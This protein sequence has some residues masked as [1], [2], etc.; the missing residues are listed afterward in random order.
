VPSHALWYVY[1]VRMLST[2]P[3]CSKEFLF[4]RCRS[5]DAANRCLSYWDSYKHCIAGQQV[6]SVRR[7]QD[8]SAVHVVCFHGMVTCHIE[9]LWG[10]CQGKSTPRSIGQ[11]AL[12]LGWCGWVC[13]CVLWFGPSSMHQT[14]QIF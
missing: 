1:A 10:L 8:A 2:G 13:L 4:V 9:W 5:D 11:L 6:L 7:W 3:F 14:T 12:L